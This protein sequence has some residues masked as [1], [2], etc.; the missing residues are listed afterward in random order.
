V[1]GGLPLAA[2][3]PLG[4]RL[5]Q[6]EVIWVASL[7]YLGGVAGLLIGSYLS[8]R[9]GKVIMISFI[10]QLFGGLAVLLLI[11]TTAAAAIMMVLALLFF[12][13][14]LLPPNAFTLLQGITPPELMS[15]ATGLM[16]GIAVGMGVF[17]PIVL[18]WPW[19]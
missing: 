11:G 19:P 13:N 7:P 15:S 18:G 14:A 10:F 8:D 12:F 3:L 4:H 2:E 17:G 1:V 5:S 9:T 16:N 6:T